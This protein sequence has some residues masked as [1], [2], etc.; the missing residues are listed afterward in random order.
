MPTHAATFASLRLAHSESNLDKLHDGEDLLNSKL[1]SQSLTVPLTERE[2]G[3]G[4]VGRTRA[5]RGV[6][7]A[8]GGGE[9]LADVTLMNHPACET[10]G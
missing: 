7:K 4:G 10:Q 9:I 8:S 1:I 2:E 6:G 5:W 3:G